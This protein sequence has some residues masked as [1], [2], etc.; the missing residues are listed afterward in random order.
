MKVE[1][2]RRFSKPFDE[3]E[4]LRALKLLENSSL[5]FVARRYHCSINTVYLW[6]KKYDGTIESLKNKSHRPHTPHPN[7]QTEEEKKH[8]DDMVKRNPTAG[9]NELYGKLREN[10]AYSRNPTTLYKYLKR[11]GFYDVKKKKHKRYIP[12]PYD[13][14]TEIGVKMQL[15]VKRVPFDCRASNVPDDEI[16]YQYTIIDECTRER[17]IYAY[18]EQTADST[19]DF[20]KRAIIFFGYKPQTIQTDNGS[21]FTY[22]RQT[23]K[24]KTHSFDKFCIENGIE[25]TTIKPRTP[26][27]NGKVERSHRNDNERFYRYLKF[28]SFD[29]LQNQMKAYLKRSNKIPSASLKWRTPEEMR[30][31]HLLIDFGI[32]TE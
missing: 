5:E 13:T 27:H 3:T 24:N 28:Y 20:V 6:R 25:H 12:K 8:I 30:K 18:R 32:V 1:R 2:Q 14:P 22:T 23:R 4:K 31:E 15:D 16:F 10:Y 7:S 29:D 17:F 11:K 26:R 19:V 9:L 21:E